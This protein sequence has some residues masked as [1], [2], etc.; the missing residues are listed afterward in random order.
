MKVKQLIQLLQKEN[1]NM[2]VLSQDFDNYHYDI[3]GITNKY[4]IEGLEGSKE[5]GTLCV[6]L[7]ATDF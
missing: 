1:Q 4:I 6:I 3:S 2:D 5:D 7:K